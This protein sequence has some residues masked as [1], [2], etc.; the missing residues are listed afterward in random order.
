[1]CNDGDP[2]DT[3]ELYRPYRKTALLPEQLPVRFDWTNIMLG[4][5]DNPAWYHR[6]VIWFDPCNTV[7]PKG[8]RAAFN[9]KQASRGA[10]PQWSSKA[11]RR[12]NGKL[13][14][15]KHGGK[16][17]N[18]DDKRVWWFVV[19]SRG[20]VRLKV[21]DDDWVQTGNGMAVFV[22]GLNDLLEDM[23]GADAPKPRICFTDRGPGLYN[24]LTGEIVNAYHN[25]LL[26]N[27]F[28]PFAGVDGSWQ[29]PDLAD[30]FLY[31]TAV[32]WVR[33]WLKKHP[34][35]A[36]EN[37]EKNY[38]LFLSRLRECEQHINNTYDVDG[39]CRDVV[40]RLLELKEKRG[41][42]MKW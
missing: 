26:A 36:V 7:V 8:R 1:M 40:K 34:F 37:I 13:N 42:R 10:A 27:G 33:R 18:R 9:A 30:F 32:V 12:D 21:M 41:A 39:V 22:D 3:W 14:G 16:Q 6:N 19:L 38:Q 25:S 35:K 2:N 31:E 11:G 24:S 17:A 23:L 15:S 29:P 20:V 5:E 4:M 28:R